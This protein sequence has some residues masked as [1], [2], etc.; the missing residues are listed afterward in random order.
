M[1][2]HHPQVPSKFLGRTGSLGLSKSELDQRCK[3][4]GLYPR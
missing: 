2:N 4:S 1:G 3:A